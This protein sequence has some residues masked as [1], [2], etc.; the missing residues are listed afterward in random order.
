MQPI[1][2]IIVDDEPLAIEVLETYIAKIPNLKLVAKC[3]HALEAFEAI[4]A[5]KVDLMFLDIQMPQITGIDFLKTLSNPPK[6]I[7]TTAYSNYAVEGYELNAVDYLLKPISFERFLKAAQ[8]AILQIQ[9]QS[10]NISL[11]QLDQ[12]PPQEDSSDTAADKPDYIF[13]KADK[14]LIKLRFEQILFIEGLKDYVMIYTPTGRII[15]LQTMKSLEEKLPAEYFM[16][17]HRSFIVGS[18]HID[19][20]EGNTLIVDK[21]EI[22]VGKNYKDDLLLAINKNRL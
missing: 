9:P 7:F 15:T 11:S 14:K 18:R 8:K 21:K 12:Q 5:H 2:V 6:V 13:V 4:H 19:V 3:S 17:V 16:R 1:Q 10:Q 22:P 20:L